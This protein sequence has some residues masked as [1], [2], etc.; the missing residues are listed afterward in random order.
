MWQTFSL[1]PLKSSSW[2]NL[3]EPWGKLEAWHE[4]QECYWPSCYAVQENCENF[5]C[6]LRKIR[7]V[8]QKVLHWTS[9]RTSIRNV[10]QPLHGQQVP[11]FWPVGENHHSSGCEPSGS[12]SSLLAVGSSGREGEIVKLDNYAVK[13]YWAFFT[14]FGFLVPFVIP[15]LPPPRFCLRFL[16]VL[17]LIFTT[18]LQSFL[19]I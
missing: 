11:L 5:L 17:F 12:F 19:L 8:F 15:T 1:P 6:H 3:S 2:R 18:P 14:V 4:G 13:Y 10:G 9:Q 16:L 7:L